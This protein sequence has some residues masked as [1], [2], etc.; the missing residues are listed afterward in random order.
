MQQRVTKVSTVEEATGEK[1]SAFHS[2]HP[3]FSLEDKTD[4]KEGVMIENS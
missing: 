2:Q 3:D 4:F 1:E